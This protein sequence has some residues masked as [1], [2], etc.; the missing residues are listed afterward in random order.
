MNEQLVRGREEIFFGAEFS[1]S[2]GT[3]K[4]P[5]EVVKYYI[6][7]L[8]SDPDRLHGSF[9][10]YRAFDASIVQNQQRK[11][12]RLTLPVLAIGAEEGLG[13]G[14]IDTMK[15]VADD[16]QSMIISGSGHWIAE[17]AP[18]QL[19]EALT[20]FLAPYQDGSSQV[21]ALEATS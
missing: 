11:N 20:P 1:G 12:T 17:Q 7:I 18:E 6:D 8:A 14:V 13:Q 15:L 9:G 4:L 3:R 10:Q 5:S 21:A 2:A 16:L 19:I